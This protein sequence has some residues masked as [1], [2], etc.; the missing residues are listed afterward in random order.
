MRIPTSA[1]VNELIDDGV[2]ICSRRGRYYVGVE[3][4]FEAILQ[5]STLL[6]ASF[7][8]AY[9]K[10]L[11]G[12]LAE[13]AQELWE[14]AAP[15]AGE[16][17]YTPRC[18]QACQRAGQLAEQLRSGGLSAGHLLLAILE[19]E[20][21][22]PSRAL[23]R[24]HADR[25]AMVGELKEVLRDRRATRQGTTTAPMEAG[26]TARDETAATAI[27]ERNSTT[28]LDSLTRDLTQSALDGKIEPAIGRGDLIMEILQVLTRKS[29]NNV[30]L[31]GE[32][33]VGKTK[34][35][36]GL[37]LYGAQG[38]Y[39]A[40]LGRHRVL[41][42]SMG[43][44]MAGTEYR[45]A[46]E[47]RLNA[48]VSELKGRNDVILFID[49]M[50]LIMGAGSTDG[51]SVDV[52]NMLKPIL[53]RGELKV[54]GATT[55]QE[56]RKYVERDPALERRFQMVRVAPLSEEATYELLVAI[57][58]SLREHH[59]I[60][61]SRKACKEV[62][63]LT[64][65][66]MPNRQL[67]DKAIDVLDQACARYR[68][69]LSA[70]N[71]GQEWSITGLTTQPGEQH[72]VT[73]HEIRKVISQATGLPLDEL[74]NAERMQLESLDETLK[75][76]IIGQDEAVAKVVSAVKRTKAG[77]ANPSRPD[78][79]MLFLGPS[80]VGKTQLAK[81]LSRA[82]FGAESHLITFDM[83]EYIEEHSVS[84]LLGAPPGYQ[85]SDEEGRLM[86][87]VRTSP[88]S[89]LLFDEIEKAHP[90]V[91]DVFL[92]IF[93]EG[94]LK[95][96]RGREVSFKNCFII[97][98][99][100]VG[101]KVLQEASGPDTDQALLDALG[102]H[103]RPEFINR[104]DEI[105]RFYPLL[106]EDQRQIVRIAIEQVRS[107]VRDKKIGIRMYQRAYEYLAEKGY[108]PEFGARELERVVNRHVAN[109]ISDMILK[110]E[111]QRGDVVDVSFED[112]T[113]LVKKGRA[114]E[115]LS[116]ANT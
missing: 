34:I 114:Q 27:A 62:I 6:P 20:D 111:I 30:V 7:Y 79:I 40:L 35:V 101:T 99:S 47:T 71:Q 82:L 77:L 3:H 11:E 115:D 14:G 88:Y 43:A 57:R 50:H 1:E 84:K 41:E 108:N 74:T 48:L 90:R 39:D 103:F 70:Y 36:E 91:F 93:D 16:V 109:P 94:R 106:R 64:Q 9:A 72:Q 42:L 22:G 97:L 63:R 8:H 80:G 25:D 23:D 81:E 44:L 5:K 2:M 67:P 86:S 56:Y 61:I 26:R 85:G 15:S 87:A 92:P 18:A 116:G 19:D 113:L 13:M 110:G 4:L 96:S 52:A 107:R 104:I 55:I 98:T 59:K 29:K 54:I 45:G 65:R 112:G 69:K 51:S 89:I 32:A 24:L 53:A 76:R 95:D 33:G 12:A 28:E 102:R 38:K 75:K 37:A 83:S 31:V 78:S 58:P 10:R 68:L 73:L 66:Y 46:L 49:E 100:N 105:V 21:S 60:G 17:F